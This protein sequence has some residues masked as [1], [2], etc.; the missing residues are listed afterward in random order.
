MWEKVG[1]ETFKAGIPNTG[2]DRPKTSAEC[3]VCQ[4]LGSMATNDARC[5]RKI[6][7][8]WITMRQTTFSEKNN[9]FASNLDINLRKK[10]VECCVWS[11]AV[12]GAA[13]WTLWKIDRKYPESF[14]IRFW[15]MI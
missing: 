8:S 6:T 10:L 12:Y 15:R 13:T 5:T 14:E 3:A 9:L 2:Y 11:R 4:I 1:Y 7:K